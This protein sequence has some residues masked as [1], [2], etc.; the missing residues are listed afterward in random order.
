M[1]NSLSAQKLIF[2]ICRWSKL[3]AFTAWGLSAGVNAASESSCDRIRKVGDDFFATKYAQADMCI[4]SHCSAEKA[5]ALMNQGDRELVKKYDQASACRD[6]ALKAAD[7]AR[8]AK[9]ALDAGKSITSKPLDFAANQTQR[10]VDVARKS[11]GTSTPETRIIFDLAKTASEKTTTSV[12]VNEIQKAALSE[13]QKQLETMLGNV[14]EYAKFN[15]QADRTQEGSL[16]QEQAIGQSSIY[17]QNNLWK[18][19]PV[20][21]EPGVR[22]WAAEKDRISQLE[23]AASEARQAVAIAQLRQATQEHAYQEY[24]RT[25]AERN[26][27]RKQQIKD[28]RDAQRR[29]D[30]ADER[31]ESRRELNERAATAAAYRK[32]R[33][34]IDSFYRQAESLYSGQSS[35]SSPSTVSSSSKCKTPAKRNDGRQGVSDVCFR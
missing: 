15:V 19:K 35:E 31:R 17:S 5:N 4:Q 11:G 3:L 26:E 23:V 33:E 18:E 6:I 20:D 2:A 13:I 25:K 1:R 29:E 12:G 27:L 32:Q 7:K 24:L 22:I 34:S 16:R 9:A 8:A 28:E 21:L 10:T 30:D 14:G